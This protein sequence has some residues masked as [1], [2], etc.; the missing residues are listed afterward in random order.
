VNQFEDRGSV[1]SCRHQCTIQSHTHLVDRW[2]V[3]F[4]VDDFDFG[5]HELMVVAER[6]ENQ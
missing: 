1:I 3:F 5:G 2:A 6:P 4:Q